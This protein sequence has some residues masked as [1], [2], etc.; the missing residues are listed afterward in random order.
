VN[1]GDVDTF[2]HFNDNDHGLAQCSNGLWFRRPNFNA[3][4]P[5]L[6]FVSGKRAVSTLDPPVLAGDASAGYLQGLKAEATL[7]GTRIFAESDSFDAIT[8]DRPC[9]RSSPFEA[10]S[11]TI[12]RE[13]A[14]LFDPQV[15]GVFLSIPAKTW[16]TIVRINAILQLDPSAMP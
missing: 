13:A 8:S 14:R 6:F 2:R 5:L 15:V 12:R 1:F 7:M 16:S 4:S 10:G 11:E 9:R 3:L